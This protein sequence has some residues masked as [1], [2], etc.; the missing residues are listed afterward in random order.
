M[1]PDSFETPMFVVD[2]DCVV[3]SANEVALRAIGCSRKDVVG[4]LTCADLSEIQ[5]SGAVDSIL[6]VSN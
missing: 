5:L 1:K 6:V 2:K 4:K 3:T